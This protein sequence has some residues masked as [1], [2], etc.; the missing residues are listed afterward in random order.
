MI[1]EITPEYGVVPWM[2]V[3]VHNTDGQ[4][5][6]RH[7]VLTWQELEAAGVT[8]SSHARMRFVVNDDDP[9][10]TVEAGID[11]FSVGNFDCQI[12]QCCGAYMGGYTGNTDCDTEGKTNLSDIT[13]LID[14]VY[15]SKTP[16][17]CEANGNVDGDT[18]NALNLADITVLIDHVYLSKSPTALCN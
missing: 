6:W 17:C 14:R 8:S 1:V 10:S 9:Q 2:T 11:N 4:G 5:F 7:N 13:T 16:L 3:A 15:L 12:V 18:A